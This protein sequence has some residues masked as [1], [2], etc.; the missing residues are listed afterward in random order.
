MSGSDEVLFERATSPEGI[1]VPG[2]S[3]AALGMQLASLR[4][5]VGNLFSARNGSGARAGS[6]ST[7]VTQWGMAVQFIA[8]ISIFILLF[9]LHMKYTVVRLNPFASHKDFLEL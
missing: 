8:L 2:L 5:Q 3:A 9:L 1:A 7:T 4:D 6:N